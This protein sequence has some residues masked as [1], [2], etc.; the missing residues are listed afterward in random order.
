MDPVEFEASIIKRG[1][2]PIHIRFRKTMRGLTMHIKTL[3]IVEDFMRL[4]GQGVT[5]DVRTNGR[6]WTHTSKDLAEK[7]LLVYDLEMREHGILGGKGVQYRLDAPGQPLI[8]HGQDA[9]GRRSTMVNLSVLRLVGIS[10]GPGV[11]ITIS[12]VY[13][14]DA[15]RE[16]EEGFVKAIKA[17]YEA[18]LRP[19]DLTV[20][21]S[22]QELRPSVDWEVEKTAPELA[23]RT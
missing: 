3:P 12:G 21:V 7:Q 18:Y 15:T 13:S 1:E 19:I 22:T 2:T 9:N 16:M 11:T 14:E 5:T 23:P 17:F 10:E 6:Y 20:V 8:I 4:L